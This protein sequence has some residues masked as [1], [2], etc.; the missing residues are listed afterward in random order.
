[1]ASGDPPPG[2]GPGRARPRLPAGRH[3]LPRAFVVRDQRERMLDAVAQVVSRKGYPATT[4]ADITEHAGVS[5]RTFYDQFTDKQDCFLAAYEDVSERLLAA[6]RQ[7]Y[8]AC[9]GPWPEQVRCA[10]AALLSL[11]A[12]QPALARMSIIDVLAAGPRALQ[13]RDAL[14]NSFSA[15]LDPGL[16]E[17]PARGRYLPPLISQ[18]VIGGIY[19][20]INDAIINERLADL[21]QLLPEIV[22]CALVPYIGH[23]RAHTEHQTT[24][25][26]T[27][28]HQP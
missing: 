14:I 20:I 26:Q 8:T 18:A 23:E 10:L 15:L 12:A 5:R 13:A 4:I 6:V 27:Q 25:A 1:M 7:A 24:I 16:L 9:D 19:E 17:A 21:P 22:Y 2:F 11:F 28:T 3:G